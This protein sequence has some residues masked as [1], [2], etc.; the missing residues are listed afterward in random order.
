MYSSV[1]LES[2]Y[3]P[4][5]SGVVNGRSERERFNMAM[6]GA[7]IYLWLELVVVIKVVVTENIA[8]CGTRP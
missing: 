3:G 2:D 1:V 4:H 8:D 7:L 6:T 5:G